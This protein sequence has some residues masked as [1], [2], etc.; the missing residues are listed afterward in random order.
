M[1]IPQRE[2]RRQQRAHKS[3]IIST[4]RSSL[5]NTT[6]TISSTTTTTSRT[7]NNT[8]SKSSTVLPTHSNIDTKLHTLR[9]LTM[10]DI[11]TV[12]KSFV[13]STASAA[14]RRNHKFSPTSPSAAMYDPNNL[15]PTPG[16]GR[17][18]GGR[19][20]FYPYTSGGTG[21]AGTSGTSVGN[22]FIADNGDSSR[23]WNPDA[24][25]NDALDDDNEED[26]DDEDD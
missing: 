25:T 7:T 21:S 10:N 22:G 9:A 5:T 11:E 13:P 4:K 8:S 17:S 3:I 12:L 26:D 1:A 23:F 15:P 16:S 24:P 14:A 2:Q 6:S 19:G 18:S 20:S